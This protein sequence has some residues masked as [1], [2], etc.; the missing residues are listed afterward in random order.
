MKYCSSLLGLA[1]GLSSL[2]AFANVD[3]HDAYARAMPPSAPNSA[4]FMTL[5]NTTSNNISLI[6]ATSPAAGKVELHSHV[7]HDGLMKMRQVKEIEVP[8]NGKVVLEPGGLHV[9]FFDLASPMKEGNEVLLSLTFSDGSKINQNVPVKKIMMGKMH[10]H[11]SK[12][13]H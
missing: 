10:K 11:K 1:L 13:H 8:A 4:A 5:E 2:S 12:D 3:L 7:M 6:S 9:M